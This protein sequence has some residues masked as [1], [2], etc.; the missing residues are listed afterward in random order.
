MAK[1]TLF[2]IFLL[3]NALLI[4]LVSANGKDPTL[5]DYLRSDSV[6]KYIKTNTLKRSDFNLSMIMQDKE[7]KVAVINNKIRT[8]KELVSGAK[9]VEI[10]KNAVVLSKNGEKLE[11]RLIQKYGKK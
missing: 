11:L 1:K 6:N 7:R 9:I 3:S 2:T 4:N 10:K 5:P 8:E